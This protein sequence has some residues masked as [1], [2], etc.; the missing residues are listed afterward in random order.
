MVGEFVFL[1]DISNLCQW[2]NT[3][4]GTV[5]CVPFVLFV[6]LHKIIPR[7][8]GQL[9]KVEWSKDYF[10]R[11]FLRIARTAGDSQ[12][13]KRVEDGEREVQVPGVEDPQQTA[14]HKQA[15]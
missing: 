13:M 6:L 3:I 11:G 4:L 7:R 12:Q 10:E 2:T 1:T 14:I 15:G 5:A 9:F 8:P